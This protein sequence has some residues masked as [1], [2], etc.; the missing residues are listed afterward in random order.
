MDMDPMVG[1]TH[2]L[3]IGIFMYLVQLSQLLLHKF[4]HRENAG[5]D[6]V[7]AVTIAEDVDHDDTVDEI[8]DDGLKLLRFLP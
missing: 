3:D 2:F 1:E 8:C 7:V 5:N 4:F 6:G